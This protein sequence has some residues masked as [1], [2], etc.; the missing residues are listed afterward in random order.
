MGG[1]LE[2]LWT[3]HDVYIG[4]EGAGPSHAYSST[5]MV[6]VERTH[7]F[8]S[9]MVS[10]ERT[11]STPLLRGSRSKALDQIFRGTFFEAQQ[12]VLP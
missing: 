8:Y 4:I 2:Q 3:T 1:K 10:V 9:S 12:L 11:Q 5:S 7:F 6:S